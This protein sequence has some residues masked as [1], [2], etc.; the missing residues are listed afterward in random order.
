MYVNPGRA[1]ASDEI[2]VAMGVRWTKTAGLQGDTCK[3]AV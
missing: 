1:G 2:W 3:P